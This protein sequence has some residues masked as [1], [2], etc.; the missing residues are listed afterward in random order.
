M[1]RLNPFYFT[2]AM[3]TL[4]RHLSARL[5]PGARVCIITKDVMK[6]PVRVFISEPTILRA[7]RHGLKLEKIVKWKPPGSMMKK[8]LISKGASV[9]E[10]EDLLFFVKQ[11]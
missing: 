10:E 4:Y 3:D 6:G 7:Q 2:Q 11:P 1:G 8:V 9:V 5:V